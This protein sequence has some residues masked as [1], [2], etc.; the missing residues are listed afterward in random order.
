MP[1]DSLLDYAKLS[2]SYIDPERLSSLDRDRLSSA[3]FI[4]V[5]NLAGQSFVHRWQL[6]RALAAQAP[7]WARKENKTVNKLYNKELERRIEYVRRTFAGFADR[8]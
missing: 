4:A 7:Q 3:Q 6:A 8:R 2:R 1:T 5:E